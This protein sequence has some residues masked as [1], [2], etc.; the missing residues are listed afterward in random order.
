[1]YIQE[2]F[3]HYDLIDQREE[4]SY[5]TFLK[6]YFWMILVLPVNFSW[7]RFINWCPAV[8]S[9]VFGRQLRLR[10][11]FL[12]SDHHSSPALL[13]SRMML[14]LVYWSQAWGGEGGVS[15][16]DVELIWCNMK[17]VASGAPL[18][19]WL[20][21][22]NSWCFLVC[23]DY[24]LT[25]SAPALIISQAVFFI[26]LCLPGS[27]SVFYESLLLFMVGLIVLV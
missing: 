4:N 9:V 8:F 2:H 17:P 13:L 1:M 26:R 18:S 11:V 14:L 16:S 15:C 21:V 22:W 6:R 10:H 7:Y 25:V 12:F 24:F 19:F 27:H 3:I 23:P 20:P 5:C